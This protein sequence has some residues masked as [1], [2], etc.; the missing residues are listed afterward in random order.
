MDS[1]GIDLQTRGEV[2]VQPFDFVRHRGAMLWVDPQ[3][4]RRLLEQPGQYDA[5][6]GLQLCLAVAC[7]ELRQHGA[8]AAEQQ[9]GDRRGGLSARSTSSTR[10]ACKLCGD[11]G[12]GLADRGWSAAAASANAASLP[13]CQASARA[14]SS[15]AAEKVGSITSG[16]GGC[17][18]RRQVEVLGEQDLARWPAAEIQPVHVNNHSPCVSC[19]GDCAESENARTA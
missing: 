14:A 16:S 4:H 2:G 6:D 1:V 19:R 7:G 8:D 12:D 18:G 9:A 17:R 5:D 15:S 11:G 10:A 13:A 3:R